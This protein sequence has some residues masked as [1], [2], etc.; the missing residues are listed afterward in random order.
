MSKGS[1]HPMS[2]EGYKSLFDTLYPSLCLFANKYLDDMDI[3]KDMVQEVFI[4]IWEKKPQF[5]SPNAIKSYFYNAVKNRC[6]DF[7]K[8][9]YV[10]NFGQ[11]IPENIEKVQTE[12][13][14]LSQITT[15]EVYSQLHKA[16]ESLPEKMGKVVKLYLNNYSTNDIAEELSVTASTVRTQKGAA[17]QKLRKAL[18]DLYLIISLF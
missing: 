17:L 3:S 1:Q 16:I 13:Y 10:K 14:F 4:T 9:K 15:I 18:G 6:L 7:L 5:K 2:L 8:S 11:A 12:D